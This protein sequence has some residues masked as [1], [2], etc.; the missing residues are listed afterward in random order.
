MQ[1]D[2]T[3]M[4]I[5]WEISLKLGMFTLMIPKQSQLLDI[6]PKETIIKKDMY[7][8]VYCNT[9]YSSQAGK[10]SQMSINR[11]MDKE[12]VVYIYPEFTSHKKE[13]LWVSS[14]EED[15]IQEPIKME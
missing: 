1:I 4:E 11:L 14:N 3:A 7:P 6:Y 10:Q 8:S 12:S 9:I 13:H 15:E 5:V 2:T